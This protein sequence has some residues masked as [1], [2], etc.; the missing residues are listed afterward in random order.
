MSD[1]FLGSVEVQQDPIPVP[2]GYRMSH[3]YKQR[4]WHVLSGGVTGLGSSLA[5]LRVR[6]PLR[7]RCVWEGCP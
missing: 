2:M 6:E 7:G 3:W 5:E 4:A 1:S